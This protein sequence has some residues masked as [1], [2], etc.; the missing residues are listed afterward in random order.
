MIYQATLSVLLSMEKSESIGVSY[1]NPNGFASGTRVKAI[2]NPRVYMVG[3]DGN[4]H[5]IVSE[6]VA[7]AIYGSAWNKGIVE[8]N[9]TDLWRYVT[10]K[11]VDSELSVKAI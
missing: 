4:L 7:S 10:G 2:G 11:N 5:W 8:V 6:T 3:T 9:S 1:A